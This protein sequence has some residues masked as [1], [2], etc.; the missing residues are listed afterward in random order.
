MVE[1]DIDTYVSIV[2]AQTKLNK[3][4]PSLQAEQSESSKQIN[5]ATS[6]SMEKL[7]PAIM[8]SNL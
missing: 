7:M 1:S 3:L 8:K 2:K 5:T 6:V 4:D